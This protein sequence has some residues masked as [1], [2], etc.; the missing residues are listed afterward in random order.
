ME[1]IEIQ[2]KQLTE[3]FN[4]L[5][6]NSLK[7]EKENK[8]KIIKNLVFSGGSSKGFSYLGVLKALDEFSI[9]DN[10][11]ELAGTSIGA[12]FCCYIVLKYH[13][14]DLIKI[15]MELDL[16]WLHNINSDS[17]LNL[18][19]KYGLDSGENVIKFLELIISFKF[20][21]KPP[22]SITFID[23]WNYNPIK[24]TLT[25]CRVY[26]DFIDLELYNHIL[27]PNMSVIKALRISMSIPPLFTP[28][29]EDKYHL[30]DGGVINNYPI[31]LFK[32]QKETTLGILAYETIENKKCNNAL[33]IYKS[34]VIHMIRRETRIKKEKYFDNTITIE[35]SLNMFKIFNLTNQEKLN[36]INIG[37]QL[38]KQYL[39]IKGFKEKENK[40]Q[41]KFIKINMTEFI[42]KMKHF[43]EKS[44]GKN[45]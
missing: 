30:I 34:I 36:V 31:D 29:N 32:D 25:G 9:L 15:F 10:I 27:T 38:T 2:I 5:K 17:I 14:L 20:P 28:L 24:I 23:L 43:L 22:S 19:N 33:D 11:Q 35:V 44:I 6:E 13:P 42:D 39:V 37:Y 45:N 21:N 16:N 8:E 1:E 3:K 41:S 12:L 26:Q 7:D 4:Q 40:E 18:L